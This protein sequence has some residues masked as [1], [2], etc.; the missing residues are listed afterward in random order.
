MSPVIAPYGSWRSPITSDLI[1]AGSIGLSEVRLDGDDVYWIEARPREKG[2]CVIV[3]GS[4]DGRREDVNPAPF[5][6]RT[7]A[8]EYGG[9]ALA[10]HRG[11]VFFSNFEDQRLYRQDPG[12]AAAPLTPA[13][14]APDARDRNRRY[15][16]G[17][18]DA[19]R[20]RWIGVR[21][22]HTGDGPQAVNTLVAIE[23]AT[24]GPGRVLHEGYDFYAAPRLSPDGKRLAWLAWRHP[25]MPWV[26]T[27]LFVA[28]V[29]ATGVLE[30]ARRVAGGSGRSIFQPEWS[31]DGVLHFVSD[32]NG[33]WNLYRLEGGESAARLL[34]G[35][36]A[37][38][39]AAQWNFGMSTYAF[40]D[41]RR[42]VCSY[43]QDGTQRLANLDID[44]GAL[45]PIELPW[46]EY[47]SVR[48]QGDRAAFRCGAPDSPTAIVLL[49]LASGKPTVLQTAS[50]AA[51]DPDVRRCLSSPRHIAFPT[52]G[53]KTAHG[54][55]YP[56][57][58]PDYAGL[59]GEK[60]P[61]VVKC[62]GGP[63]ASTSTTLN[64]NTQ[65][66]T[67]RGIAVFDVDYGGSTGYGRAYRHRLHE[68][69][70]IVDV[71]DCVNGAR[72]LVEQGLADGARAVMTGGSAGGY[73]TLA[74]LAFRDF[75]K[76]GASHYGV[77]DAAALARDTHKFESRYLDWLIG[78]YPEKEELYRQRSPVFHTDKLDRPIAFF[79]GDQDKI[80]PPNQTELMVNALRRR[81]V[82]VAY[83][84]FTGEAHGFRQGDNIK[85]ALDAELYF[86]AAL[87][88]KV[89]LTF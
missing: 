50:T 8:H 35:M 14:Q 72:Y 89:Q 83:F 31:P 24:G 34:C 46:T 27:E 53:G 19:A 54:F 63:T 47:S 88:F 51:A 87:I 73:T 18:V 3:R 79:Q 85:R 86:Y 6:S 68:A 12:G 75:F 77:S 74:A 33:W 71:D 41:A 25:H 58:N 69:W 30:N 9:G 13:S 40:R 65:F 7:R 5:Y 42:L 29:S 48:A 76:G 49:D 78:P 52:T 36:E 60:P 43:S 55:Y 23:L 67:S 84:L 62:H 4:P 61:L 81:N 32:E 11:T 44:S 64:L 1:V 56:P 28:D 80:V 82:P 37:E 20:N 2:R 66:W 57:F 45:T 21:E 16:D 10:V 15:A 22:D 17:V 70:G 39:G 59:D 26:E 38:F